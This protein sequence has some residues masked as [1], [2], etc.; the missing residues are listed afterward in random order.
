LMLG[1]TVIVKP[2]ELCAGSTL[3]FDGLFAEAGFPEDVY[4]TA[5][6]STRQASTYIA[7]SRIRA[8]T[9]TGSDRAG[10]AV[11]EQAGRH[12]KPVVLELGGSDA[13][14][15]LDSAD[16]EKA[17]ATASFCRLIINGQ[18]CALPKRIIV[19][20]KVADEF[21]DRFTE[22]FTN[23]TIGDPFEPET[24]L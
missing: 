21:I 12:I 7:D 16:V 11:A 24:T 4:Q 14:V 13:Y 17:A 22:A 15:V 3:L 2:S 10:S 6:I 5:L 23:Q 9:L 8:V 19:T 18:A 1:N 20:E